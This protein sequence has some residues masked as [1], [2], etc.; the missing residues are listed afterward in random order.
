LVAI[1]RA[2][3]MQPVAKVSANKASKGGVK[4]VRRRFA[5][6]GSLEAETFE[7]L[8]GRAAQP[9]DGGQQISYIV[10]GEF[11][12]AAADDLT[13]ARARCTAALGSL[14]ASA[15]AITPGEPHLIATEPPGE[16]AL[17]VAGH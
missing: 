11:T 3:R 5:D 9:A 7:V 8:D 12:D 15:R 2:G 10:G 16:P 4:Q 6:D 13:A 14:P 1:E 17:S